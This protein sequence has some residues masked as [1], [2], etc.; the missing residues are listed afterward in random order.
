MAELLFRCPY[1]NKEI[2]TGMDLHVH[3][4]HEISE[5]PISVMCPHCGF[6]HHGS[7]A[8]GCLAKDSAIPAPAAIKEG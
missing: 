1:T 8:D 7:I 4:L 2:G 6:R 3:S 5:Y